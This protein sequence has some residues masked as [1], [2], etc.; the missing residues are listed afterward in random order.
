MNGD[1]QNRFRLNF[2][3]ILKPNW[4]SDIDASAFANAEA[5]LYIKTRKPL[6]VEYNSIFIIGVESVRKKS[7]TI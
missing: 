3:W 6:C 7:D 5:S 1:T 4:F 2:F